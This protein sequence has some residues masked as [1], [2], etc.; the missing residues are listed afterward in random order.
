MAS[1]IA[2]YIKRGELILGPFTDQQTVNKYHRGELHD[3]DMA[4]IDG[5]T[6]WHPLATYIVEESEQ[7][8]PSFDASAPP[9]IKPEDRPSRLPDRTEESS[10]SYAPLM[11]PPPRGEEGS[12]GGREGMGERSAAERERTEELSLG[13]LGRHAFA[14]A[15]PISTAWSL[16]GAGVIF[17]ILS[18]WPWTLWVPPILGAIALALQQIT[19]RNFTQA[20]PLL[21]VALLLPWFV[22][23]QWLA[24]EKAPVI[25]VSDAATATPTPMPVSPPVPSA[26]SSAVVVPDRA[27]PVEKPRIP[28]AARRADPAP[29]R[30]A[31][32]VGDLVALRRSTMLSFEGKDFRAG[33]PGE[34]FQVLDIRSDKVYLRTQD[35]RGRVIAVSAPMTEVEVISRPDDPVIP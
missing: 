26:T 24:P 10:S 20:G 12:S 9:P 16:L 2:I 23:S 29:T 28:P 18:Q 17:M 7:A 15:N 30:L 25:E 21:A 33:R 22:Y 32:A 14:L 11:P 3:S 19:R 13:R 5:V 4:M 35:M 8:P 27:A 1:E 34:E 31:P 6:G